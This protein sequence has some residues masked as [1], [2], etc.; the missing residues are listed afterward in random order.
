MI[1]AW[2]KLRHCNEGIDSFVCRNDIYDVSHSNGFTC[3]QLYARVSRTS[4]IIRLPQHR[5]VP[6]GQYLTQFI[7]L[8]HS[9]TVDFSSPFAVAH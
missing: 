7:T 2:L 1:S 9:F 4:V 5:T 8:A 3:Y 6:E